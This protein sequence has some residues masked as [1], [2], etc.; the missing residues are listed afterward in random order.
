MEPTPLLIVDA[1]NVV[2]SRPNGW[3]RDRAGAT[4]RLRDT[5]APL[6]GRGL[7]PDLPPPVEVVLV[8]EGAARDVPGVEGVRVV[9]AAGS[10]DDAVVDL[11][12]RA[13][14]RRRVVVTADRELR[15]RVTGYGAEVR[16][17]RWLTDGGGG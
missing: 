6:G 2:G 11:V 14:Q 12:A 4:A 10:G 3:W 13:G 8:V 16:G 1:A 9:S 5:L 7:P 17:P 15:E